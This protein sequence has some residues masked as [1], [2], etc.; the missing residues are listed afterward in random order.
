[1]GHITRPRLSRRTSRRDFIRA[2]GCAA[3]TASPVAA[4]LLGGAASAA[5][6]PRESSSDYKAL[7][8]I[9][10]YGGNDSNNLIVPM[11][12]RY[13]DYA[14]ARTT[15]ALPHAALRPLRSESSL[16]EFGLHPACGKLAQLFSENRLAVLANVGTLA[17]DGSKPAYLFNHAEQQRQWQCADAHGHGWG[18]R[19]LQS[20]KRP[21]SA[22]PAI[23]LGGDNPF[24]T[25]PTISAT[26]LPA[27]V[28]QD[29]L[30]PWNAPFPDNT[31]GNQL[32]AIAGMI[33]SSAA[34]GGRQT[35]F[36]SLGGFDLHSA[37]L[38]SSDPTRG[39]HANLLAELSDAIYSFH[40]AMEQIGQADRVVTFTAS[41]F[42]RSLLSNGQGSEHG[43]GSHQLIVGGTG[44]IAGGKVYGDFPA[45]RLNSTSCTAGGAL[46]PT[47][48][49]E[50]SAATL[51]RWFG[52]SPSAVSSL[53]PTLSGRTMR[54]LAF[55]RDPA[56]T[57][58]ALCLA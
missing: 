57:A 18:G 41:E 33:Q 21:Q 2:A 36:A 9:F 58:S 48:S 44:A 46:V 17:S 22:T 19:L 29:P 28:D 12:Y 7:V 53:F 34:A 8:C 35:Y 5:I 42:G 20:L 50:Q 11:D 55:I 39:S 13:Q 6:G 37:Q 3:L 47:T 23:S 15:L 49:V 38:S 10:L 32:R 52:A 31:L 4:G 25:S 27:D 26:H 54:D 1:M 43:W 40:R 45:L 16:N 51:A 24:Q 30:Q 56:D 14:A